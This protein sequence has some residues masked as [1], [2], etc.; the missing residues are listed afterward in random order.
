MNKIVTK[1]SLN[2]SPESII[3]VEAMVEGLC[4]KY[5][6]GDDVFGNM[7]V[8]ITEAVNNAI[9]HGNKRIESKL[10]SISQGFE[11]DSQNILIVKIEDEGEGFDYNNLPDPTAP[12]NITMIGG[13]GIF[14]IKQLADLV[15]FNDNGNSIELHFKL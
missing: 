3:E 5:N 7:I 11:D 4:E 6:I 9:I 8:S 14:L 15:I 12:E 13:R 1:I 2:S 10:V